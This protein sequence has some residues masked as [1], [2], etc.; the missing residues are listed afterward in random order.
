MIQMLGQVTNL[1]IP[2]F[3]AREEKTNEQ[4]EN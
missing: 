4:V 1:I 2:K 3:V